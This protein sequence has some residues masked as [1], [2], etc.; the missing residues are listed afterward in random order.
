M[1]ITP[2]SL[3]PLQLKSYSFPVVSIRAN[4]NGKPTGVSSVTQQ[5]SCLPV[6][7]TPNH[8]NLQLQLLLH[9][10]DQNNPFFYEAEIHAIGV[11]ELVGDFSP[12]KREEI[13]AVNG[14]G[15]LYSACREMLLNVTARSVYGAFTIPSLNFQK[16]I[17]EAKGRL[18]AR[19]NPPEVKEAKA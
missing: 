13:A 16:V 3:S 5:I 14:L 11:V 17:Q 10:A 6:P 19:Q 7:E 18:R 1:S 12:E 4:P 9:S 8:W 15:I 2:T